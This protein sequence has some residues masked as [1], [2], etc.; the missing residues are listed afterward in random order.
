[1]LF[2][3]F[4]YLINSCYN[5]I[6]QCHQRDAASS[7]YT[8]FTL[9]VTDLLTIRK[10]TLQHWQLHFISLCSSALLCCITAALLFAIF[11]LHG[12]KG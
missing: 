12:E 7:I 11:F 2:Y 10:F 1:M 4:T 3:Y 6:V 9:P 5:A 8:L